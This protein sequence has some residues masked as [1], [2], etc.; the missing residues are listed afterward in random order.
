MNKDY[1]L[2]I[3]DYIHDLRIGSMVIKKNA[4]KNW[5]TFELLAKNDFD[6][7]KEL[8][9]TFDDIKI[10]SF[11]DTVKCIYFVGIVDTNYKPVHKCYKQDYLQKHINWKKK[12]TRELN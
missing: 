4:T 11:F 9:T 8:L 10:Y 1:I 5:A 12:F 6:T 7:L 3:S 2:L